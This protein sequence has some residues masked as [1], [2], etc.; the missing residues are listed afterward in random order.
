MG[1]RHD[2][3]VHTD[4]RVGTQG[5]EGSLLQDPQELCLSWQRDFGNLVE[6]Q[7]AAMGSSEPPVTTLD[8]SGER[9]AFVTEELG[10][11]QSI[12][13]RGA[14]HG[15]EGPRD[16][17][18]LF[19][20]GPGNELL[21]GAAL[22]DNQHVGVALRDR[23]NQ[24]AQSLNR[25]AFPHDLRG[26]LPGQMP[27]RPRELRLEPALVSDPFDPKQE[28]V[29]IERL[30]Q[31]VVR[32]LLECAHRVVDVAV[33]G[34]E[35]HRRARRLSSCFAKHFEPVGFGHSDVADHQVEN[36]RAHQIERLSAVGGQ[37]DVVAPRPERVARAEADGRL[38]V[39]QEDL[40][41]RIS[42]RHRRFPQVDS[43]TR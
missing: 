32:S 27:A 19:V 38:V 18:A 43:T 36:F 14:V 20:Q 3:H 37:R 5:L 4:R 15:Y 17:R 7:R 8:R 31:V 1:R 23:G 25:R 30:G 26:F 34:H 29:E 41:R 39:G 11:E 24:L 22:A 6:E 35:D 13:K 21:S 12:G 10:F 9:T 33:R 28:L 42:G 40:E 2:S 16:T